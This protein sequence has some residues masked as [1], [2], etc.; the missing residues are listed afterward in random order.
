MILPIEMENEALNYSQF[1]MHK[2]LF[3]HSINSTFFSPLKKFVSLLFLFMQSE[4]GK[5][6]TWGS[7]DDLG[8]SFLTSGQHGVLHRHSNFFA[9]F[10]LFP[11]NYF[12]SCVPS[13]C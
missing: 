8:Q 1:K 3:S 4:S 7:E 13:I 12:A 6:M 9:F 5:L 2:S 11:L 10:L